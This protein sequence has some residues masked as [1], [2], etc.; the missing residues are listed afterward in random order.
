MTKLQLPSSVSRRTFLA[1]AA[2]V[3]AAFTLAACGQPSED[4][5]SDGVT[6]ITVW[7][8]DDSLKPV[9]AAFNKRQSK[10]KAV[11][12]KMSWDDAHLKLITSLAAGS[13]APDVASLD[14]EYAGAFSVLGGLADLS[15]APFNGGD[16]EKDFVPYKWEQSMTPDGRLFAFPWDVAPAGLWY[17]SDIF[18]AAGLET[19]PDKLQASVKEWEDWF[20]LG[21]DLRAKV[22][23]TNLMAHA[24]TDA[25][26]PAVFQKGQTWFDEKGKLVVAERCTPALEL[27]AEARSRKL[28]ANIKWWTSEW[29]VGVTRKDFATL[30]V[31]C[32][33]QSLLLGTNPKTAGDWR[34]IHAPGGDYSWGGGFF[35]IPEQSQKKKAAWEFIKFAAAT[36]EGQNTTMKAAGIFPAYMPAWKDPLYENPVDFYGGQKAYRVWEDIAL[37]SPGYKLHP[38]YIETK[39]IIESYVSELDKNGG[40][41]AKLMQE[42]EAKI[43]AQVPSAKDA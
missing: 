20:Q 30:N 17:R 25:F 39:Q 11:F 19:D 35:A 42:A 27:A 24:Y 18:E 32:W 34:V 8:W 1:A 6:T 9:V 37:N 36:A 31:A 2:G 40:D 5:S 28:D 3:G 14:F 7:Y 38:G 16:F 21:E 15:K 12:Q 29:N 23:Q 22:P 41:P 4:V 10:V 43:R 13:G 33:E 26:W